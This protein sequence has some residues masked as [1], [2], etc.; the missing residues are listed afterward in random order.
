MSLVA[1]SASYPL[2]L[3]LRPTTF[4]FTLTPLIVDI[5]HTLITMQDDDDQ[6]SIYV[7]VIPWLRG[8]LL[9]YRPKARGPQ[10]STYG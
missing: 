8:I 10:Y 6:L 3:Y 4:F 5:L 7:I 9:I 2:R 1:V